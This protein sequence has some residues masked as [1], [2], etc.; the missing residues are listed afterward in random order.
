MPGFRYCVLN[1][2][3]HCEPAGLGIGRSFHGGFDRCGSPSLAPGSQY[4]L[5]F[6]TADTYQ[7]TSAAIATYNNDVG[8]DVSASPTL[9]ALGA[10]WS[11]IG[12]TEAT[13]V[14]TN[15]TADPGVP[16][17]DLEGN[18]I[19]SDAS[20]MFSPNPLLNPIQF[21][22]DGVNPTSFGDLYV[23]TG[24]RTS[25]DTFVGLALGDS[26]VLQG[27]WSSTVNW[28]QDTAAP[29]TSLFSLYGLSSALTVPSPAPEPSTAAMGAMGCA[30]AVF[31]RRRR[32][33]GSLK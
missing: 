4:R 28:I 3:T 11:D 29:N 14:M 26:T 30:L 20:S 6:V 16:V 31:A 33:P 22:E 25:G 2:T 10:T 13:N 21:D 18:L 5:A 32:N 23:W 7:A 24:T 9:S 27:S 15:I 12:S 1:D 19:A 17:Y 8:I